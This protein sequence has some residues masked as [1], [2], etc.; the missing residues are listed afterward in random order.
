MPDHLHTIWTLPENDADFSIRWNMLKG[1]F[2][3]SITKTEYIST[4]RSKRGE[5]GIWQRRF[6]S[7]LITSQTDYNRHVDYIHW[8][9]IKHGSVKNLADWP[10]SSF[11]R[12]VAEGIYPLDWACIE[13]FNFEAGE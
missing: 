6:W 8:N 9:P 10:H 12:Y 2:S 7:H 3:G 4:S 11:H 5:R 13:P 1:Q